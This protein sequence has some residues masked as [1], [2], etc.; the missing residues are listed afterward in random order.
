MDNILVLGS[1]QGLGLQIASKLSRDGYNCIFHGSRSYVPNDSY[2]K[3]NYI[4]SDLMSC[5]GSDYVAKLCRER[6]SEIN[7]ILFCVGS[8]RCKEFGADYGEEMSRAFNINFFSFTRIIDSFLT[9]YR[10][11]ERIVCIS[12]ICGVESIGDAPVAYSVAKSSLHSFVKTVSKTSVFKNTMINCVSP[13]NISTGHSV[14]DRRMTKDP[15][16]TISHIRQIV[17]VGRLG[18]PD[19]FYPIIEFL[20]SSKNSFTTGSVI[21][22]DG[23]QTNGF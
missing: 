15:D 13:G 8:G 6:Y 10:L 22:I 2:N 4:Q 17:P 19:D 14:W 7:G 5:E 11:P 1:S 3:S 12:S 21:T 20:L 23:G 9:Y 18:C 16:T